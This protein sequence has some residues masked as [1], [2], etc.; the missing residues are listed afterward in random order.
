MR[1]LR[2]YVPVMVI[3]TLALALLT[4][5]DTLRWEWIGWLGCAELG[6]LA[7]IGTVLLFERLSGRWNDGHGR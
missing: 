4:L 6:T 3:V 5:I 1:L 7:G 2:F